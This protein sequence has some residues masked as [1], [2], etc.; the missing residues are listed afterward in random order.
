[1]SVSRFEIRVLEPAGQELKKLDRRVAEQVAGKLAWLAENAGQVHHRRLTGSLT[2]LC[3]LR[4]GDL[5]VIYQVLTVERTI[6]VHAVGHRR[7]IY[8]RD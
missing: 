7:E 6:L 8:R 2:G 5:R 4:S 3:R 1:M